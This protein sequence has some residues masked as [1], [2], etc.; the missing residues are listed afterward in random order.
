[1]PNSGGQRQAENGEKWEDGSTSL[2]PPT[3]VPGCRAK[4]NS[5]TRYMHVTMCI[6]TDVAPNPLKI[7]WTLQVAIKKNIQ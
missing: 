7:I 4:Q 2:L 3:D 6:S 5:Y 1:M